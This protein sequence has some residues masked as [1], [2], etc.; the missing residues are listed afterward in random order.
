MKREPG[1]SLGGEKMEKIVVDFI[2]YGFPWIYTFDNPTQFFEWANERRERGLVVP[3]SW[4]YDEW[5]KTRLPL[6]VREF[7]Y[8]PQL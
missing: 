6:F 5:K 8:E 1:F 2:D 3:S 4:D 7:G